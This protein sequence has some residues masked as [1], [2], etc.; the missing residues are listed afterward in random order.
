MTLL[1]NFAAD[2]QFTLRM[3]RKNVG[4]VIAAVLS[5]ALGIGASS[6]IFSL[7][8]AVLLDPYPYRDSD[9]IINIGF[10]D[11]QRERGTLTYTIPDFLEIQ[12]SSKTLEEVAAREMLSM[13]ATGPLPE[14]VSVVAFSPNAFRHFGVP[15]MLGRTFGPSDVPAVQAPPR[16]A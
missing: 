15:A 5:L 3:T 11:K 8:H 14:S 12:K 2:L 10:S 7:V 13:I 9:R 16:I 4:F 6:A 1:A